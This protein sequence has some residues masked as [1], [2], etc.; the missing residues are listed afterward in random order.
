MVSTRFNTR[1]CSVTTIML[2]DY[3]NDCFISCVAIPQQIIVCYKD[4]VDACWVVAIAKI[5]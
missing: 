3:D 2:V 1:A 4:N 5:H